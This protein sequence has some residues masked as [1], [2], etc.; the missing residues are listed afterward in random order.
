MPQIQLRYGRTCIPFDF[1]PESFDVLAPSAE[2]LP[3]S[4]V[5]MGERL[6]SPIGSPR[7][8]EIVKPGESVLIVVPDATREVGAGRIVNLLVRR[9]IANGTAPYD[10]RVIIAT[11][12]HR[13][14]TQAEKDEIL[15]PFITQRIKVL[16]H[17]ARDIARLVR[18]GEAAGGIPV[19]LNKA[20]VEHD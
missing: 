20:L 1:D 8:E 16:D 10:V 12:I 11:G 4:D 3:L 6:D 15:T 7:I 5:E 9:L 13:L 17:H 19:E 14:A 18:L 2:L